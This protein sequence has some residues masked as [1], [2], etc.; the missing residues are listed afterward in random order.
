[1]LDTQHAEISAGVIAHSL[2]YVD[3]GGGGAWTALYWEWPVETGGR[4]RYERIILNVP[5]SADGLP[6]SPPPHGDPFADLQL[7]L[8]AVL[9]GPV[10]RSPDARLASVRAFLIGFARELVTARAGHASAP[11]AASVS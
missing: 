5:T 2:A 10:P 8:A 4:E 1:V 9:A 7:S 6:A 11:L 3:P